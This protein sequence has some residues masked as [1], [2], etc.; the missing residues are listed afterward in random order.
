MRRTVSLGR[1]AGI[2]VGVHWTVLVI[3]MLLAQGLAT[4]VLPA[5]APERP[6]GAYWVVALAVAA[7]FLGSVLAHEMAHA[8]IARR[9]GVRVRRITL[10]LLGGMAELDG[11]PPHARADLLIALAGPAASAGCAVLF[12]VAAAGVHTAGGSP[13]AEASLAWLALVNGVLAV[14]NLLPG[15]PLD[16]GRVLRAILWWARGDRAAAQRTAGR[17]GVGLGVLLLAAGAAEVVFAA[18]VGGLWLMLLGAFLSSAA[19][20]E[21]DG[22]DLQALLRGTRVGDVMTTRPVT[23]GEWQSVASFV[24]A[25]AGGVPHRTFPVVDVDGTAVGTVGLRE[26]AR[27][28]AARRPAV[29]L[30]EVMVPLGRTPVLAPDTPLA[31]VA[32]LPPPTLALVVVRG[33]LVGVLSPGDIER[34]VQLALLRAPAAGAAS[35]RP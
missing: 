26:F 27:V 16:G 7:T 34:A 23:G 3:A 14:F 19:R 29:R 15:A 28:P 17:L 24:E 18:D 35:G 12:G 20:A 25:V 31:E 10:W 5:N 4:T 9:Y 6:A 32:V 33:H 2:P 13:L 11:Q 1:I 21:Q 30:R 8:L 22:D